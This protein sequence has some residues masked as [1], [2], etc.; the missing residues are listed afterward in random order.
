[1][2]I[3]ENRGVEVGVTLHHPHGQIYGYPFLPPV[4]ALELAAD[5]RLGGCAPCALLARELADG[6]RVVY[7]NDGVVVYVPYAARWPYEVHA[8]MREH[9]AEPARLRA[10]AELR[11]LAAGLQAL[12][13]GYDALFAAPFPYVMVVHQAPTGRRGPRHGPPA[14]RVLPAAAHRREAQVPRRLRAGR[15]HVHRRRRCPRSPPRRCA[16]RSP[17][18]RERGVSAFAPGRVNLIG[19]HTDYNQGLALPFAIAEGVTV[20]RARATRGRIASTRGR[21]TGEE[22]EFPLAA[23]ARAPGWRAFVRGMVAELRGAGFPLVGARLEIG[24]ELPQGSGSPPRPRWRWR[25]ASRCCS[26]RRRPRSTAL[27]LARGCARAWRTSGW[28]RRRGLLDQLASL[29]GAPDTALRIDF[30]TLTIEPVPLDL[31]GGWRL[32]TLDSGERHANADS[33]YNERRRECA[34]ACELLGVD[35]L[36]EATPIGA[37]GLPEPLRRRAR[38]VLE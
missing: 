22:D 8:V 6:R 9:R 28:A 16:R 19:E 38:H 18:P 20:A 37:E 36:R 35:S 5:V 23:P 1:M 34:R 10:A 21:S 24:G 25:C 15:G 29:Y 27:V 4:P 17:V 13:R 14:R 33:G 32:V 26:D 31:A 30:Q 2:L 7:E 3:F 12:T 11:V